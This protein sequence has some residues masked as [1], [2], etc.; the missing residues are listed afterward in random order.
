M[1]QGHRACAAAIAFAVAVAI[2]PFAYAAPPQVPS[3]PSTTAG[4]VQYAIT[5]APNYYKTQPV[6]GTNNTPPSNP[7]TD[8]GA[9]LGR[10]LFYDKRLSHDNG[11]S[12]SSCHK[13]SKG[14]SDE[15]RFSAG[16]N[17]QLTGRHAPGLSNATFYAGGKAFWD[18]RA[19]SLEDQA[20]MPI[21]NATEMG[22][23]L[24]EVIAKLSA[25]AYYPTLFNAAFGDSA[26]TSDR[27]GKAIAQF[28]RSMVTYN[29]EFD[30]QLKAPQQSI[31][32]T[33]ELAGQVIFHGAGRCAACHGT[34]ARVTDR[35]ATLAWMQRSPTR[36]STT[37]VN[38]KR[39][40]CETSRS[41]AISC[42]TAVSHLSRK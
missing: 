28:E 25:T 29:S 3:L 34:N 39:R 26:V 17:G 31:L 40:L 18:E 32:D 36:A 10:V 38:S 15:N 16:I 9:T 8:A 37:M 35:R 11:V 21:Q 33:D 5:D 24:S 1:R 19:A 22:S 2:S 7:I 6:S 4:Y 14:F 27:I 23:T 42:T 12:C 30:A 20:L 41:A 13:Q